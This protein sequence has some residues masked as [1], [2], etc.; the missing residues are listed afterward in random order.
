MKYIKEVTEWNAG[1]AVPNHTYYV[2]DAGKVAIGYIREG[3]KTL[4]KF[5]KPFTL[6]TRGRKFTV[7]RERGE[8]DSVYFAAVETPKTAPSAE[9]R[10]VE[11]S[12]GKV[13]TLT[14]Q[15]NRWTCSC[16]GFTFRNTCKH[17]QSLQS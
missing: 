14:K 13:Y 12:G 16:P 15:G 10:T 2:N 3:D 11:G 17:S 1:Y 4:V 9:T 8:P 5:S 7:L 6:D